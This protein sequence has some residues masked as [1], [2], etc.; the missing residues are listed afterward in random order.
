VVSSE[1]G[2]KKRKNN[3]LITLTALLWEYRIALRRLAR[4][5]KGRRSSYMIILTYAGAQC[6]NN[7]CSRSARNNKSLS[8]S[9]PQE[10]LPG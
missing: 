5:A 10:T 3:L 4:R 9:V 7:I 6:S 2:K 8:L 1:S